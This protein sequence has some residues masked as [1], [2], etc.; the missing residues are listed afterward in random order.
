M[1]VRTGFIRCLKFKYFVLCLCNGGWIAM[2][3]MYIGRTKLAVEKI[4]Q[5][6]SGAFQDRDQL[7]GI[8]LG[9]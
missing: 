7:I 4:L 5:S 2:L 3:R 1:E 9:L 6:N 8:Q